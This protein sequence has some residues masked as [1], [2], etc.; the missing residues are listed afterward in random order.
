MKLNC[1]D[2]HIYRIIIS[3][4]TGS[5]PQFKN[6]LS[7]DEIKKADRFKF[8][9]D[10]QSYTISRS[11]LR[12]ILSQYI[13]LNP[14]EIK[15]SYTET[16]KPFIENSKIHFNLSHSGDRCIIAVSLTAGTGVDIEK[17]RDS[18]DLIIIAERYFSETEI[19]YLK[20]FQEKEV[21][22]NFFRIWTLKEAFI[23]AIGEGL[24]FRLKDFSV[25]DR[26]G[27][28]PVLSFNNTSSHSEKNWSLQILE[29]ES[30][31]VSSFA[32]NSDNVNIIYKKYPA[33]IN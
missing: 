31:Y 7:G 15:F 30:D 18:E 33:A 4:H 26:T 27:N 22:N 32:I 23:K 14:A 20:N 8:T 24:S 11:F 13:N 16:G 21:T 10:F 2:V 6:I 19:I 25:T 3:E 12:N 1:N 28:I 9:K 5:I 17:V 29:S